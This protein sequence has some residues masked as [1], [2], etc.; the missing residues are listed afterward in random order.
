[1][2]EKKKNKNLKDKLKIIVFFF[3]LLFLL[4]SI[5]Y[6]QYKKNPHP[7]NFSEETITIVVK[8][9]D[10]PLQ[11][12]HIFIKDAVFSEYKKSFGFSGF[13]NWLIGRKNQD[14]D[15]ILNKKYIEEKIK[16]WEQELAMSPA[17]EGS[18]KIENKKL[19]ISNPKQGTKIHQ[20][21]IERSLIKTIEKKDS[22]RNYTI[23]ARVL[24]EKPKVHEKEFKKLAE[25]ISIFLSREFILEAQD[26]SVT[27]TV[28][29]EEIPLLIAIEFDTEDK[30]HEIKVQN[31]YLEENLIDYNRE[32]QDASFVINPDNSVSITPSKVGLSLDTEQTK[33]NIIRAILTQNPKA[34]I[35]FKTIE[36]E[37]TT[38]KAEA[39]EIKHPTVSFTTYFACC[40]AR[41]KNIYNVAKI[42]DEAIVFPDQEWNL[43]TYIGKRTPERG[44]L[45]AGT[46][47]KGS[48]IETVG[49]GISQFATTFYN[50]IYWGGYKDV[51]HTPHSRYFSR[52]PEGIEA[53]ISWPEPNLIFKNNTPYGILVHTITTPT[54]VTVQFFGNN[55][56]RFVQGKHRDGKTT[57]SVVSEGGENSKIVESITEN[58]TDLYPPKEIYYVDPYREVNAIFT[59]TIGR[60]SYSLDIQ[61]TIKNKAGTI[62][63][64]KKWKT[65]Y[66]SED[67]EY[68]VQSCEFAP[69]NSI[70]KTKE[71]MENEKKAL[72]EFF[73]QLEENS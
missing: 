41:A 65:Y 25:N 50:A 2:S 57:I 5:D 66:L 63:E 36:P 46:I 3:S 69:E 29:Q 15:K 26:L 22:K 38:E 64:T 23:F 11:S 45:P 44:F 59:K 43:N 31:L 56:G 73:Q 35:S 48:M 34:K 70:C 32:V 72:E 33:E 1:M 18:L 40:E 28:S 54:S 39:L 9:Q 14:W 13:V 61:R 8:N 7:E 37:L 47:V 24:V 16:E 58:K 53:T 51:Q 17:E 10:F 49:G 30:K 71:D 12:D 42:V 60:P 68:L 4:Y 6:I 19:V 67:T 52:Y 55:D 27:H 21:H 20:T 62:L